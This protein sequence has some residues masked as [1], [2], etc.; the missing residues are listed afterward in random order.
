M[1]PVLS[2]T[3]VVPAHRCGAVPDSHRVPSCLAS[4]EPPARR[5]TST[6]HRNR[7]SSR[8][9]AP[10]RPSGTTPAEY[11]PSRGSNSSVWPQAGPATVLLDED[12]LVAT[13]RRHLSATGSGRG[14]CSARRRTTAGGRCA[15]P[16]PR[17]AGPSTAT[18]PTW[19]RRCTSSGTPTP[20]RW[21]TA[22][23]AWPPSANWLQS[24]ITEQ[25]HGVPAHPGQAQQVRG[26]GRGHAP[27][28]VGGERGRRQ[29]AQAGVL[30]GTSCA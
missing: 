21:S 17:P 8:Q 27:G 16:R 6:G 14:R 30:A 4:P 23:S 24:L 10:Q 5:T 12:R 18:P 29:V 7:P 1:G 13:L 28:L 20:P 11:G 9:S 22:G 3:A 19:T 26:Q 25:S 15:T 2:L